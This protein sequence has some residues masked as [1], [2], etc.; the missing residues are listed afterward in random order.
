MTRQVAKLHSKES[1]IGAS[2]GATKGPFGGWA[3]VLVLTSIGHLAWSRV[4]W[5]TIPLQTDTGIW[6]YFARRMLEGA[7]LYRDLWESKPPGI[8]WTFAIL[9]RLFGATSDRAMLWLDGAVTIGVCAATFCLARRFAS[10]STAL[11]LVCLLSVLMNH[12]ILADWGDNL[13]KFVALFEI[14]ALILLLPRPDQDD[15]PA[16]ESSPN[17]SNQMGR[18][19]VLAGVCCGLGL[20]FK[21]TAAIFP[22]LILTTI[23]A[24]PS[25]FNMGAHRRRAALRFVLGIAIPWLPTGVW[26]ASQ[27]SV[28]Q[29]IRQVVLHDM[30][31]AASTDAEQSQLA[32]WDH[33]AN[34]GRHLLLALAILGPALA[35]IIAIFAGQRKQDTFQDGNSSRRPRGLVLIAIYVNSVTLVFVIAPFGYGH[36][37]LHSLPPAIILVAWLCDTTSTTCIRA[38]RVIALIAFL[39]GVLQLNDHFKFLTDSN[40]DV[41]KA[42]AF[43]SNRINSLVQITK[44]RTTRDQSVMLW[45]SNHTV[46]YYADRRTPLEFCQAIDI[47]RG[48]IYLLDPP[49]PEVIKKLQAHPPDAIIDWTPLVVRRSTTN[50]SG[51]PEI[52]VPAGGFSL[53]EDPNPNHPRAEGRLL[54]PLKEWLRTAYGGQ[55]RVGDVCT[56]YYRGRHWRSWGEILEKSEPYIAH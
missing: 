50:P 39:F 36:Y 54:A 55:E 12:R 21:Q 49:M 46:N 43:M 35:A 1:T 34:V 4:I 26:L 23:L 18:H 38:T 25:T 51:P 45:E 48:R 42:Y 37:L 16:N 6:A 33:W 30:T 17:A 8:F 31:R 5:G 56:V 7:H 53:A 27:E 10:R 22:A 11:W 13:E 32:T 19:F 14:S 3:W 52:L 20:L 15:V 2:N 47:F 28:D 9:E 29:F 44:T 24:S 41:R 40:S